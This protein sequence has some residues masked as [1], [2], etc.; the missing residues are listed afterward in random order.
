MS[1][2]PAALFPLRIRFRLYQRTIPLVTIFRGLVISCI[3]AEV[4]VIARRW[5]EQHFRKLFTVSV[6]SSSPRSHRNHV[7]RKKRSHSLFT[8]PYGEGERGPS[9]SPRRAPLRRPEATRRGGR[10]GHLAE[11][12]AG[13]PSENMFNL[14]RSRSWNPI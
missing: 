7:A 3:E 5:K 9:A 8:A 12:R 11:H 10:R 4:F 1:L 2:R 13:L 14:E 6:A